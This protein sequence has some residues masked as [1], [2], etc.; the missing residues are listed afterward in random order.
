MVNCPEVSVGVLQKLASINISRLDLVPSQLGISGDSL[1]FDKCVKAMEIIDEQCFEVASLQGILFGLDPTTIL[2]SNA[3]ETRLKNLELVLD[4][5]RSRQLVLGAPSFRNSLGVWHQVLT[6]ISNW[7]ADREFEIL[8]ENLCAVDCDGNFVGAY[9]FDLEDF[10]GR[11]GLVFDSANAFD[12]EKHKDL[13]WISELEFEL[14]H[15]A[16]SNHGSLEMLQ[17]QALSESKIVCTALNKVTLELSFTTQSNW[18]DSMITTIDEY[19]KV[20]ASGRD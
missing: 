16:G 7:A 11:I 4:Y 12:C 20:R 2:T 15:L 13:Q 3:L 6:R 10:W 18:F 19:S 17:A 14:L 5:S 8:V 1:S 9:G